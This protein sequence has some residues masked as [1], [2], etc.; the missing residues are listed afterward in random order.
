ML[1]AA[2][3]G[4]VLASPNAAQIEAG[5]ARIRSPKGILVIVK[6]YTGDKLNFTLAAEPFR[7]ASGTP[8]RLIVVADDI[9]IGRTRSALY[10]RR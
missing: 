10:P 3:C 6:N 8:V 2:V 7:L 9:S 4:A 5:L 1:D